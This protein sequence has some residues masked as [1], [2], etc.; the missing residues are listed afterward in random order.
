MVRRPPE[1]AVM[2]SARRCAPTPRP[3]KF[4]GHVV[5][6]RQVLLPCAMAGAARVEAAAA[7]APA[8]HAFLINERR[9]IRIPPLRDATLGQ[10]RERSRPAQLAPPITRR[11]TQVQSEQG[12]GSAPYL[13]CLTSRTAGAASAPSMTTDRN[14][15]R[16]ARR[17]HFAKRWI[18]S[19]ES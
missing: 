7:P 6:M 19:N 14:S 4:L 15:G 9:S 10:P 16:K 3:G 11:S 18:V 13:F 12:L 8:S 1:A 5:T 2:R 17:I